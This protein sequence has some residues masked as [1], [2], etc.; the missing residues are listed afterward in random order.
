MIAKTFAIVIAKNCPPDLVDCDGI[1]TDYMPTIDSAIQKIAS[2]S[3][4]SGRNRNPGIKGKRADCGVLGGEKLVIFSTQK[5]VN[6][7]KTD[8]AT[9]QRMSNYL[10]T[11]AEIQVKL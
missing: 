11:K 9:K 6:C 3:T 10:L 7:D 5:R 4:K 1:S 2:Q 8:F